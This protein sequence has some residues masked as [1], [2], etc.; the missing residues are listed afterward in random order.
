M[1][2]LIDSLQTDERVL[3]NI[4]A[5]CL[6]DSWTSECKR[7]WEN[8]SKDELLDIA[9]GLPHGE[10]CWGES[11]MTIPETGSVAYILS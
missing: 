7:I 3:K 6:T 10:Y 11:K 1:K 2:N 4:M 5:I 8:P 9:N